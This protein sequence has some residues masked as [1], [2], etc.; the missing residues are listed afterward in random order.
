ML[1]FY[2]QKC[3]LFRLW[4]LHFRGTTNIWTILCHCYPLNI[5]RHHTALHDLSPDLIFTSRSQLLT[6]SLWTMSSKNVHTLELLEYI[7][8]IHQHINTLMK[9]V[10]LHLLH[11]CHI[12]LLYTPFSR[13]LIYWFFPITLC[14]LEAISYLCDIHHHDSLLRQCMHYWLTHWPES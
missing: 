3:F 8:I 11:L 13:I 12:M 4:L 6:K 9:D 7:V 10:S 1:V 14:I 5:N 2:F